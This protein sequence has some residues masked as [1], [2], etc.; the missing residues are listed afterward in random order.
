MQSLDEN[1]LAENTI[2]IYM[3]DHGDWL[4]DHGLVLKGPMHYEGLLRVPLI[5]RGPGIVKNA[6]VEEPVSTL[7]IGPTLY[8]YLTL[9][10]Q[11]R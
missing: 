4:G 2:V 7:D 9:L 10:N 6:I 8:D 1:G 5:A 3:S 11:S